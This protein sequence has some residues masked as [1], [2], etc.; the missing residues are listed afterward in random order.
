MNYQDLK[1]ISLLAL[2]GICV[3]FIRYA[4]AQQSYLFLLLSVLYGYIGLTYM[5]FYLLS[6]TDN[7]GEGTFLFG[8]LYVIGSAVGVIFLFLNIKKIVKTK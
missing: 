2:A 4:L 8:M 7:I 6:K 5:I 1:L 3:Y